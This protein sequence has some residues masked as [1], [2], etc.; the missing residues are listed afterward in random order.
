MGKLCGGRQV[1]QSI[2]VARHGART[3]TFG[4]SGVYSSVILVEIG[5]VHDTTSYATR[6]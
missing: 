1:V 3:C 6:L 4:S 5:T 2:T